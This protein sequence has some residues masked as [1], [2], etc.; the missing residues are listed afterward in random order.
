MTASAVRFVPDFRPQTIETDMF[1]PTTIR[2]FTWHDYG[3]VYG[4]PEKRS[5]GTTPFGGLYICGT[6]QGWVG[7]IGAMTS[8]VMMAN[9]HL[10]RE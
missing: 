2:R 5:D 10:L 9:L 3:A 1:T 6:D 8:G 4:M 7:I